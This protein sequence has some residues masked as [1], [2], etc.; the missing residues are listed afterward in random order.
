MK[1]QMIAALA[2]VAVA[3]VCSADI[4]LN[5][6]FDGNT[7]ASVLAG[8]TDNATGSATVGITDWTTLSFFPHAAAE[9][10]LTATVTVKEVANDSLVAT[11]LSE[12]PSPAEETVQVT[13]DPGPIPDGAYRF[14]VVVV[15]GADS[16]TAD[17]EV[18]AT[19]YA[20][21]AQ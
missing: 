17:V 11:L 16:A 12:A 8:N 3:G 4:L 9:S 19:V 7:G 15:D 21:A 20:K 2:V 13:W 6:A 5:S 18:T 10:I 1:K 14:D